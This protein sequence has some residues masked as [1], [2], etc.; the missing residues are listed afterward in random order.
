MDFEKVGL[1]EDLGTKSAAEYTTGVL[2]ALPMVVGFWPIVLGGAYFMN[3]R[4]E[5]IA[6]EEQEA[7]VKSAVEQ[8][9]QRGEAAAK[10]ALDK[11]ASDARKAQD[12]AVEAAKKEAREQ[13]LAEQA[14]ALEAASAEKEG[15]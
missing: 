8:E 2:G 13:L 4:K 6:K 12:K 3:K 14:A 11:A 1:R 5:E 7:A 15:E 10:K 9:R